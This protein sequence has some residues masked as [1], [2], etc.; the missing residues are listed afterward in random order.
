MHLENKKE[1]IYHRLTQGVEEMEQELGGKYGTK[2]TLY[3]KDSNIS[4]QEMFRFIC[5]QART[6][7]NL[8]VVGGKSNLADRK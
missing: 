4:C 8:L 1:C 7:P 2:V 3:F 6:T 5:K